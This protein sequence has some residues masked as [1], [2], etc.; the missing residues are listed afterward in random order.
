MHT[1]VRVYMM[2]YKSCFIR[3]IVIYVL[4]FKVSLVTGKLNT[5]P[6]ALHT[7]NDELFSLPE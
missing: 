6:F 1:D 7:K 3:M 4:A 5:I 2:A